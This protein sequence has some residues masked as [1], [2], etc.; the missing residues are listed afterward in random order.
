[1][2]KTT[3]NDIYKKGY[4]EGC[5]AG[6]DE[7]SDHHHKVLVTL[8]KNNELTVEQCKR[9]KNMFRVKV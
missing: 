1:M 4:F 6:V 8:W 3:Y 2:N 5:S 7:S 9:I